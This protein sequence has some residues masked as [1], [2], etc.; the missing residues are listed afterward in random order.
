VDRVSTHRFQ[1]PRVIEIP[2]PA[3]PKPAPPRA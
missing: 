2:R 3:A 1:T